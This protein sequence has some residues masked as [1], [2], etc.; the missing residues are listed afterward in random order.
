VP[1]KRSVRVPPVVR[2]TPRVAGV[3]MAGDLFDNYELHRIDFTPPEKDLVATNPSVH[4]DGKTWW[5]M[6]RCINYR[7]GKPLPRVTITKNAI[8]ELDPNTWDVTSSHMVADLSQ[9]EA[10]KYKIHGYEDARLF[11]W[12]GRRWASA[13]CCDLTVRGM[14][15][16]VLLELSDDH[17]IVRMFPMRGRWSGHFQKNWSPIEDCGPLSFGYA[18]ERGITIAVDVTGAALTTAVYEH[19]QL[20]KPENVRWGDLGALRGS[21]QAMRLPDGAWLVLVHDGKY[22]S[23]FV[24]LEELTMR[25]T[26]WTPAFHFREVGIEFSA[27]CAISLERDRVV[28]SFSVKDATAELAV[29]PLSSVMAKL[30]PII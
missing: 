2:P 18:I 5:C 9:R 30:M 25:M 24:R 3:T 19:G 20:R 7:L 27:G 11:T 21:S 28:A 26:H 15:E 12:D 29:M 16:L 1:I 17:D 14:R 10:P 13:T 22:R 8:V 4:F 6:I 23:Q